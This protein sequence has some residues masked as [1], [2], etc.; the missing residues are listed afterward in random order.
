MT[1]AIQLEECAWEPEQWWW[2]LE[3]ISLFR[4]PRWTLEGGPPG[5]LYTRGMGWDLE[6]GG[7]SLRVQR[8]HKHGMTVN[9]P[10]TGE[11]VATSGRIH[12]NDGG[13]LV[14]SG[15]MFVFEIRA[16]ESWQPG[17]LA[18]RPAYG[19]VNQQ[20][21]EVVSIRVGTLKPSI[22]VRMVPEF[23]DK[24]SLPLLALVTGLVLRLRATAGARRAPQYV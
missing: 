5:S 17:E 10:H 12:R 3:T 16:E 7:R 21:R 6:V 18:P 22:D 11:T 20:G 9:N 8:Q 15:E 1:L 24:V 14:V 19:V 2:L 23:A 4:G 13:E